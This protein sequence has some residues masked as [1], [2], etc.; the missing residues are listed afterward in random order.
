MD[1][2][3]EKLQRNQLLIKGFM[4]LV[5]IHQLILY[6]DDYTLD[7]GAIAGA[8]AVLAM[9]RGLLVSPILLATPIRQWRSSQLSVNRD[10][11]RYFFIAILMLIISLF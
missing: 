11:K 5:I 2:E 10:G 4:V 1:N 3:Q 8:V 7:F 9:L 6:F